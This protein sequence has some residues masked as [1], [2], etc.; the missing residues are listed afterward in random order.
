M[1]TTKKYKKKH[2]SYYLLPRQ[3]SLTSLSLSLTLTLTLSLT[4]KH[5]LIY[6]PLTITPLV[7]SLTHPQPIPLT[8]IPHSLSLPFVHL[9]TATVH[10]PI[11][12]PLTITSC[13]LPLTCRQDRLCRTL[14][15]HR[16]THKRSIGCSRWDVRNS[17]NL[18][19][20]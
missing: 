4:L 18:V 7:H 14:V 12:S 10:S 11:H 15:G 6:S 17:Q 5:F 3:H 20:S 13:H 16:R 8:Y 1:A 9:H 2:M 19:G